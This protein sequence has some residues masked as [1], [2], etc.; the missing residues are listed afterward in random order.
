LTIE[1]FSFDH[2]TPPNPPWSFMVCF[3]ATLGGPFLLGLR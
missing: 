1:K 2:Q 3:A